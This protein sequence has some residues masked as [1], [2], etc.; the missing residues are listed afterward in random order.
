VLRQVGKQHSKVEANFL[1]RIMESVREFY[2]IYFT[3]MICITTHQQKVD[4][5]TENIKKQPSY[6]YI[7]KTRTNIK[8]DCKY[9]LQ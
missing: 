8:R 2:I 3:I 6:L 9:V 1:G 4:L 7:T 5:V